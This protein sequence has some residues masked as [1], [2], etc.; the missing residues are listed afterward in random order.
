MCGQAPVHASGAS[1]RP[2]N[3]HHWLP[4]CTDNDT[5]EPH[6][7]AATLWSSS[8]KHTGQ[9]P[10]STPVL[11]HWA[12]L[13][14]A[15]ASLGTHRGEF[16]YKSAYFHVSSMLFTP[17][18]GCTLSGSI[19]RTRGWFGFRPVSPANTWMHILLMDHKSF[20]ARIFD[21]KELSQNSF[22]HPINVQIKETRCKMTV[23]LFAQKVAVMRKNRAGLVLSKQVIS[24]LY[25]LKWGNFIGN[26]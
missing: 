6:H 19:L 15:E 25:G 1:V 9:T 17:Q 10:Q 16:I 11:W 23:A 2:L 3:L 26:V 13:T 14:A 7:E 5:E 20:L 4:A 8:G 12:S 24:F 18:Q 22:P 21:L